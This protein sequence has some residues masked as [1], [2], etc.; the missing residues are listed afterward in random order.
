MLKRNLVANF[1]GQTWVVAMGFAF[2]PL[3]IDYL[4]MESYGL[5]GVFSVMTA[6]LA[7][8][9]LGMTPT[10][11]REMARYTGGAHSA[12]SIK[13]V[14]RTIEFVSMSIA[15]TIAA[16]AFFFSD[17]FATEWFRVEQLPTHVVADAFTL[18]GC[19][20]ALRFVE[21]IYRSCIV[22]LQRQ[23]LFNVI[24]GTASTVRA[25][26]AVAVLAWGPSTIEAFFAWQAIVSLAT[27]LV[28]KWT[29]YKSL[30]DARAGK[31]SLLAIRNIRQFATGM[32]GVTFLALL[33]TQVDKVLLS[34]LLSLSDFGYYSLAASVAGAY[35]T[36]I[37]P[38]VQTFSPR[39]N[40]HHAAGDIAA[41]IGTFHTGAQLMTVVIGSTGAVLICFSDIFLRLWTSDPVLTNVT[42]PLLSLLVAG[43]LLNGL[44]WIPYQTQLAYG[45]L[46]PTIFINFI[47]VV[48]LVPAILWT[49]PRYGGFGTAWIWVA[50][51]SA[52]LII[53]MQIMFARILKGEKQR[54][55]VED[56][57]FPLGAAMVP[58]CLLRALLP[59]ATEVAT[60]FATLSL[61]MLL[62][63]LAAAFAASNTRARI[64]KLISSLL[65][66]RT[67]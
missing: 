56:V 2:V 21:S 25:L 3:Y 37:T 54:W 64:L 5:I 14:L 47:S 6:W 65:N 19:V 20:A 67:W 32:V 10:L 62:S 35:A 44:V 46:R 18:M 27:L 55:Y 4:G 17:W 43:N 66:R 59:P 52:Y 51:N 48:F 28:L 41:L 33:L 26:G 13:D 34:K 63:F 12:E 8:L 23:V 11:S 22:G 9:D 50:L 15:A 53:S 29:T 1:L 49:A 7:L 42:A 60:C 57:F 36:L 58:V 45:W 39:L 16:A 38:I 30:P 24:Q 40:Q 31:F 61:A